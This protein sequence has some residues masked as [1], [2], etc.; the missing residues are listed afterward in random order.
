M[1]NITEIIIIIFWDVHNDRLYISDD[2]D[3]SSLLDIGL[4]NKSKFRANKIP[5]MNMPRNPSSFWC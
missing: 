1:Q 5:I 2:K 3:S 4:S